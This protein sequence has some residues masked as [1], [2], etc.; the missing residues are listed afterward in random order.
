MYSFVNQNKGILFSCVLGILL[1]YY[2]YVIETNK[3]KDESYEA[4]CDISEHM[5]C[6]K[7]FMSNYGKGFG[8]MGPLLGETSTLN[9]PNSVYGMAFYSIVGL[10]FPSIAVEIFW[11]RMNTSS[12]CIQSPK[13]AK[14]QF[15]MS[16]LSNFGSLYLAYIL[17]FILHDFCVVCV[18][19]YVVNLA[20]L[21]LSLLRYKR[22]KELSSSHA[23]VN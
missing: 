13:V 10:L 22:L 19:T 12:G 15:W 1:S 2:A 18:S 3:E 11:K 6:S 8:I 5:S 4:M 9:Q 17:A 14:L 16:V 20:L 7:A 23:K 21:I